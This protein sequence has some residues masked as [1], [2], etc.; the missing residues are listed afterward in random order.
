VTKHRR[1]VAP[2]PSAVTRAPVSTAIRRA[3]PGPTV[4]AH[5]GTS[6]QTG[7]PAGELVRPLTVPQRRRV[8]RF[9]TVAGRTQVCVDQRDRRV[10]S[11]PGARPRGHAGCGGGLLDTISLVASRAADLS[12]RCRY[13]YHLAFSPGRGISRW[14]DRPG[15]GE[16]RTGGCGLNPRPGR[17]LYSVGADRSPASIGVKRHL[18][19]QLS[20]SA[21]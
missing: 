16:R 7:G 15:R 10:H 11:A 1:F 2:S 18:T 14:R 3:L 19:G 8:A 17:G 13:Q 9:E 20:R 6:A 21:R 5:P 12:R 4:S